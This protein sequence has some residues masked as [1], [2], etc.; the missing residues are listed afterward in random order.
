[1][2]RAGTARVAHGNS[3]ISQHAFPS[4]PLNR[5]AAE[6]GPKCDFVQRRKGGELRRGE[7]GPRVEFDLPGRR[8]KLVPRAGRET[9]VT[10]VDAVS[11][12]A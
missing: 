6:P 9:I 4:D 7:I 2:A 1:M 8:R 3:Q 10:A 11:E 5:G 12:S